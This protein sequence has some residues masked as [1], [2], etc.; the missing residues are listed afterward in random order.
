MIKLEI[1]VP[2][3]HLNEI[4]NAL[5][6]SGAGRIGHYES[7]LCF[8]PVKGRWRALPGANPYDGEIGKLQEADE[9]KIEATCSSEN[10]SE[11]VKAVKKAH[12][13]EEPV[14]NA[15]ALIPV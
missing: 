10:L 7:T 2:F 5:Q 6:E 11:T 8:S 12:P 1:F 9:C 13:Y 3:S 14:I 15:I 4:C